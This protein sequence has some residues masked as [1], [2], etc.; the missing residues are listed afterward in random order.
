VLHPSALPAALSWLGRP[1]EALYLNW[2]FS[3]YFIVA[4]LYSSVSMGVL[5][6]QF[7]ND[8]VPIDKSGIFYPLFGQVRGRLT[9]MSGS[10]HALPFSNVGSPIHQGI[11]LGAHRGGVLREALRGRR[12][13][14]HGDVDAPGRGERG[15][16]R[17]VHERAALHVLPSP[18][19][20][21]RGC[22]GGKKEEG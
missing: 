8:V 17:P 20:C 15:R 6:W 21:P 18:P 22:R 13:Y 7:A 5:F 1:S 12:G 10:A 2:T 9:V 11:V 19:H 4:E 3:F 16:V 14:R